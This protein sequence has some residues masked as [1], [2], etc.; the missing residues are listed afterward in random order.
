MDLLESKTGTEGAE[1]TVEV[2]YGASAINV[3][4]V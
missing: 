4:F 2:D 1:V 3:V